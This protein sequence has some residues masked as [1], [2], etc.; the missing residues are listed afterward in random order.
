MEGRGGLRLA[1]CELVQL[2]TFSCEWLVGW[3]GVCDVGGG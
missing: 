3:G 1:V 2:D